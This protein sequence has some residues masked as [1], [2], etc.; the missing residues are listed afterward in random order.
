MLAVISPLSTLHHLLTSHSTHA[1]AANDLASF[2]F[3]WENKQLEEIFCKHP[4][5]IN[6]LPF[7]HIYSAFLVIALGELF[8]LLSKAH[9]S[10]CL[11]DL[12][13]ATQEHYFSDSPLFCGTNFPSLLEYFLEHRNSLWYL[14]S[15]KQKPLSLPLLLAIPSFFCSIDGKTPCHERIVYTYCLFLLFCFEP[16]LIRF[17]FC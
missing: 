3:N 15:L 1:P 6:L 12:I 14:T 5:S 10:A 8:V 17:C 2:L 13:S 7:G 11:P 4:P 16:I 9:L